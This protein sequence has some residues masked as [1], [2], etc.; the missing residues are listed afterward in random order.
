M[1][2]GLASVDLVLV[3]FDTEARP[4]PLPPPPAWHPR[5]PL[6]PRRALDDLGGLAAI[7]AR[8]SATALG[9]ALRPRRALHDGRQLLETA[10]TLASLRVPRPAC[11]LN[12]PISPKRAVD[13][14]SLELEPFRR[15]QHAADATVNDILLTVVAGGLHTLL[16][17]RGDPSAQGDL[18]VLV[19]VGFTHGGGE[20]G[21]Q[22]AALF[23]Q[24]PVGPMSPGR[25]LAEIAARTR[26]L[27]AHR[28]E[29]VSEVVLDLLAPTP[30]LVLAGWAW[31]VNHQPL[32]NL[33]VTN[34]PG[35]PVPLYLLGAELEEAVPFVPL[36]RNLS[37]GVAALSYQGVLR[38]G[39]LAD[40]ERC[41]DLEVAARGMEQTARDLARCGGHG[42]AGAEPT[43]R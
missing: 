40:P 28:E 26:A 36:A 6:P 11:S 34:V 3:L 8:W 39:L 31:V 41:P 1:A 25:R 18:Q 17:G 2:D 4:A 7:A 10:S 24:I 30:Q 27:K 9:T 37:L 43:E 12:V 13:W 21:N 19:P 15:L 23:V 14:L 5:R 42:R 20:L 35:P 16:E 38:I 22:V 33:V 32:V 29:L